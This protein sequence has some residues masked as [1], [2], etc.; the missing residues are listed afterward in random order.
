MFVFS[1]SVE[2][3]TCERWNWP[4]GW[5][6][7]QAQCEGVAWLLVTVFSKMREERS[8]L[9]MEL[10][11]ERE[12]DFKNLKNSQSVHVLKMRKPIQERIWNVWSNLLGGVEGIG[13]FRSPALFIKTM[14]KLVSHLNK[15][16]DLFKAMGE[17]PWGY[18]RDRQATPPI[19]GQSARACE[20]EQF[21]RSHC[22]PVCLTASHCG[23]CSPHV[24]VLLGS[25]RCTWWAP[26]QH[27]YT[28]RA[29]RMWLS[30]PG[31]PR[32]ELP[33]HQDPGR[34]WLGGGT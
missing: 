10:L 17:W 18:F 6:N 7:F 21:Q 16:Q 5:G 33:S 3:R 8:D 29:V 20:A 14:R 15:R 25:P 34:G 24:P 9:K 26:M 12:A 19:T 32:M 31:F 22:C 23:L 27:A 30:Q 1:C 4:F 11:M 2:A 13:Q 28:H